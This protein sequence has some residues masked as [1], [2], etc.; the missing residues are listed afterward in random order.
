MQFES[1]LLFAFV[2]YT[3]L[4]YRIEPLV[5]VF[6]THIYMNMY[7]G[8]YRMYIRDEGDEPMLSSGGL[9]YITDATTV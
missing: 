3:D 2:T 1:P 8:V 9:I 7:F 5:C 4:L 6:S